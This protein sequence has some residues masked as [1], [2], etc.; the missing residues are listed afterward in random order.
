MKKLIF[1]AALLAA[2]SATAQEVEL[3]TTFGKNE[4]RPVELRMNQ[5]DENYVLTAH[6]RAPGSYTLY[7]EF[8]PPHGGGRTIIIH[9]STAHVATFNKSYPGFRYNHYEGELNARPQMDFVYRLPVAAGKTVE[10]NIKSQL[11]KQDVAANMAQ[12]EYTFSIPAGDDVY[13]MR[14]GVVVKITNMTSADPSKLV[15]IEHSDGTRAWYRGLADGSLTVKEGSTVY[16]DTVIGKADT[17]NKFNS[18]PRVEIFWRTAPL[19][20][21]VIDFSNVKTHALDPVFLTQEGA[22][23]LAD[24]GTYE[25]V[26][27]DELVT[28]ELTKKELKQRKAK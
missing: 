22:A 28:E 7:V 26:V 10:C 8:D 13:A 4:V 17:P 16:P 6:K 20:R 3:M 18:S 14:R 27:N 11:T 24:G 12:R 23:K 9:N 19:V 5:Q 21:N 1:M 25:A 15:I 2:G